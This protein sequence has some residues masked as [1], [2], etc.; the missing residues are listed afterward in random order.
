MF[1]DPTNEQSAH[2]PTP[3]P[4][5]TSDTNVA[6]RSYL[7]TSRV[8]TIEN[9]G[10]AEFLSNEHI[11]KHLLMN[12]TESLTEVIPEELLETH[13]VRLLNPHMQ[14]VM[15][16]Q[17]K[18]D[19]SD[20]IKN[21]YILMM[22]LYR[23]EDTSYALVTLKGDVHYFHNP[24]AY[25]FHMLDYGDS[26]N[27]DADRRIMIHTQEALSPAAFHESMERFT[28]LTDPTP[29]YLRLFL[30]RTLSE[31]LDCNDPN[32][33]KIDRRCSI[34]KNS[35]GKLEMTFDGT[36]VEGFHLEHNKVLLNVN[37]HFPSALIAH[38]ERHP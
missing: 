1:H 11:E 16:E 14:R 19:G 17:K 31:M 4:I 6:F 35:D 18:K 27:I 36:K 21:S 7:K 3:Q 34:E 23:P 30:R 38:I 10:E 28:T 2:S 15:L 32:D 29:S 25:F 8:G 13:Q 26:R 22:E 9:C 33:L 12:V 20:I 5:E 37:C 24:T